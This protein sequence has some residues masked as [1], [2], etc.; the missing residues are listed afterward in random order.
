MRLS[1]RGNAPAIGDLT[2]HTV[3]DA[4]EAFTDNAGPGFTPTSLVN[5]ATSPH[6]LV[7]KTPVL[8]KDVRVSGTP[9]ITVRVAFSKPKAN[10]TAYLINYPGGSGNGTVI[11]R[12][13]IDPENPHSPAKTEP[14]TPGE[15]IR[16]KFDMQPKDSVVVAGRRLGIMIISSDRDYT[17]RPAPGTE[18]TVELDASF[19]TLPIVGGAAHVSSALYDWRGFLGNLESPPGVNQANSNGVTELHFSLGGDLGLDVFAAGSPASRPI[20]CDTKEPLGDFE[21]TQN[22]NWG[23]LSYSAWQDEYTYPWK[24]DRAWKGTCREVVVTLADGAAHNAWLRF[25]K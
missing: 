10:L 22:P 21:P 5:A 3:P 8:Q 19:A 13:W 15:S 25:V 23:S 14:I 17:V 12:G 11:S 2:V 7:F 16:L 6:R 9:T 4:D 1:L 24:T 20:D 18:L